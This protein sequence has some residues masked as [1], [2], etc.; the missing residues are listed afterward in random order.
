MLIVID[1]NVLIDYAKTNPGVLALA[2]RYLGQIYVPREI[3]DEASADIPQSD[4]DRLGLRVVQATTEQ[5]IEAA[6]VRSQLSFQDRVCLILARD[7]RWTCLTNDIRLRRA[8]TELHIPLMWGLEVMIDLVR[9]GWM[10]KSAAQSVARGIHAINPRHI[11]IAV[12]ERFQDE[13]DRH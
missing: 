12:L 5:L 3:L 6:S 2:S 1:A 13:L 11:S 9:G 7:E 4:C 8:C 10:E